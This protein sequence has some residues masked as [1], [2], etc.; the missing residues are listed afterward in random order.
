MIE[1]LEIAFNKKQKEAMEYTK[2]PLLIIAGAGTGKTHVVVGKIVHLIKK[3]L[4]KPEEILA[5]TFTEKAAFEMEERVD[6]ALPYGYFRMWISTF[7]A[8]ADQIL[9]DE[10]TAIGINPGFRLMTDAEAVIFLRKNLFLFRLKY[11]RPLGN[12]NKFIEALLQH[13]SRL[14]DEDINPQDYAKWVKKIKKNK[15]YTDEE[16]ARF[17][18]LSEAYAKYQQIKIKES[19]MDFS[20]LVYYLLEI[21]RNRKNILMKYQQ[22]FK[23][24]LVDEF[25]DT[26]IAQ[27][28]LVKLLKPS[29]LRPNLTV[30][31]DDSQAIYKFRGASISNILSFMK[32]Y[33]ASKSI[34]LT[35]NFRSNQTILDASYTLIKHNDPDS[36][37][38]KLG[39]SKNL[40]SSGE[41]LKEAVKFYLAPAVEDEAQYVASQIIKLKKDYR[42]SDFAILVRANNHADAF[43][44][45]L[46]RSSIPYQFLGPGMLFKQPEVK[47]LIAYLKVLYDLNDSVS[48]YRVLIMDIF[49]M[50]KKDMSLLLSF[51]RRTNLSLL[52][53]VETYLS[54]TNNALY[55][56]E[57][58][59]YKKYIPLLTDQTKIM[60][61]KIYGMVIRHL[62]L[63]HKETAGQILYYLLDESKYLNKLAQYKS[64]KEEKIALNISKFFNKLKA[65]ESS[66]ED[67]SVFATVDYLD[68]SMELGESPLASKTDISSYDAVN[69]LTVHSAKGLEFP[70]I[71]L[72]N[73]TSGRFPTYQKKETIALPQEL[74]K[75]TLPSGDYHLQEERRL[76]YVGLTRTKDRAFL[77][78]SQLYGEGKKE[79]KISLFVFETLGIDEINKQILI[80]K[81]QNSQLSIFD[82]KKPAEIITSQTIPINTFSFSQIETYEMC[83]LQYKYQYILK[84]PTSSPSAASFGDTI[85]RT[86]QQFY[87]EYLSDKNIN[88][89]RLIDIFK[90]S[91]IPIGYAS[92]QH[93]QRMKKEGEQMLTGFFDTFHNQQIKIIDLEKIF[94]IKIDEEIFVTGKIDRVDENK[95]GK[96]EIID[97]KTGKKPDKDKL[98]KSLQLSIYALA[99]TDKGLYKKKLNEVNLTFYYLSDLS[100]TTINRNSQDLTNVKETIIKSAAEIRK[101]EFPPN[102]GPWCDFC[103]FRMIC[104]AWQ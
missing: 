16:L 75:E 72:V 97:Y 54:F 19:L 70:V 17:E 32:D 38:A 90:S 81:E 26:N 59:I 24:V 44:R 101:A 84:I 18:E 74:I 43:S 78:S 93:E 83:P 58:E 92:A 76:F 103:A 61:N 31:G 30:V 52:Q 100:K 9:K 82:F 21:F 86:L 65:F 46:A 98:E 60:L 85:H 34:T 47:D 28:E 27:Y 42:F 102:V 51:S 36:L 67:A 64:E 79:R 22:Q 73:L 41:D 89:G 25:Q 3:G 53:S 4:A 80:R 62:A 13:F 10:G 1:D 91:W 87:R 7:H 15:K 6:K 2:G 77:S 12:P 45:A 50:D 66:H 63:I 104:E 40:T 68:M 35:Q 29:S 23:Y 33:R 95:D 94:K 96:V 5:L 99:A 71:F 49:E 8:F 20:D 57:Y 39:I 88:K 11:F 55:K 14:K 37:E 56:K 69:I 48:F